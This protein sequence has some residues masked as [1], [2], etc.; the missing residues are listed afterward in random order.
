MDQSCVQNDEVGQSKASVSP[1]H[2]SCGNKNIGGKA[3]GGTTT[4]PYNFNL[5]S[6]D[7]HLFGPLK[8]TPGGKRFGADDE[9]KL[10]VQ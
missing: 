1:R 8:G 4:P 7:F 10:F 3:S 5:V 6:S 9:V 2:H